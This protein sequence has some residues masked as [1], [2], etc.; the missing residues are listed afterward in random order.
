MTIKRLLLSL[1]CLALLAGA[2]FLAKETETA[3]DRMAAAA[4]KFLAG[5]T[6]D[7]KKKATFD[8]DS[9]ERTR[10]FFTPQQKG[11]KPTRKG[12][13]LAEMTAKQK[14]LAKALLRAGTSDAGFKKATT[15]ISLESILADMEKGRGPVRDPEWYFFTVFG[16][17]GKAGSW[18]W[19]VEGHHL[20][21][22]FTLKDGQLVSA[23]PFVLGSNPA[24]VK[25]GKHKG[26]QALPETERPFR[27]LLALLDDGQKKTARQ[28]KLLPEIAEN[29]PKPTTKPLGLAAAAMTDKQKAALNALIEGYANRM[30][31]DASAFE[32]ARIKKAGLGKVHF[33]YGGGDGTPG[34]PYT[35]RVQG[36]TFVIEFLNE[37]KDA[38]GN[39]A[40]HIHSGWRNTQGDFGKTE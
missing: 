27:D 11:K 34:K 7:Q 6:A 17:P 21:L 13:P 37:Q 30:P 19:R 15:V 38:A 29:T 36:P 8:F 12:L 35:Y 1:S 20:S 28:P 31:P 39:P 2:A 32:L 25:A 16:T 22:S 33:A 5:L 14:D 23:T 4:D 10:W 40:N 26:L 18:G 9:A 24:T 3:A